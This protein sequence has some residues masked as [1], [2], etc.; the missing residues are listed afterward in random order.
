MTLFEYLERMASGGEKYCQRHHRYGCKCGQKRG[1]RQR[2]IE[3]A[4]TCILQAIQELTTYPFAFE[5]VLPVDVQPY[6][7]PGRGVRQVRKYMTELAQEGKLV[8]FGERSGYGLPERA[9]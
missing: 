2:E 3:R 8:R 4:K 7:E 9:M 5:R 1:W 6:V